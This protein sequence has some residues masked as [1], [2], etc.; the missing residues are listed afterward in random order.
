MDHKCQSLQRLHHARLI[1]IIHGNDEP[2]PVVGC[3]TDN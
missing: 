1:K 3:G 2:A